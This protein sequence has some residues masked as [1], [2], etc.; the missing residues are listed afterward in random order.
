MRKL[1]LIL[2]GV[3]MAIT[4]L[5]Q[6]WPAQYEG[7]MLQGFG[8]GS[9]SYTQWNLFTQKA[10][11]IAGYFDLIWMP[12]SATTKSWQ[13]YLNG[14]PGQANGYALSN[15]EM[16]EGERELREH[17]TYKGT[18]WSSLNLTH[19]DDIFDM[20]Y[21]CWKWL[22]QE[23]RFGT[24]AELRNMIATYKAKGTG[25]IE[26]VVINHK[27]GTGDGGM[28]YPNESVQGTV[29]GRTYSV[30][31]DNTNH[32]DVC[33][34]DYKSYSNHDSWFAGGGATDSGEN[35]PYCPDLDHT[36]T[37]VQNNV[38]TYLDYLRNEIGYTGFR[39]DA[40]KG[41]AGEYMAKYIN[42]SRPTFAVGEIWD[43]QDRIERFYAENSSNTEPTCAA[44]DFQL[45]WAINDAFK[46]GNWGALNNV[47]TAAK[48]Q[49][50]RYAITFVD[51]HD[52]RREYWA[53]YD[54][55]SKSGGEGC[56]TE[57]AN[58]F[59]LMMP[60]T[61][62]VLYEDYLNYTKT[63]QDVIRIRH[64]VG[65]HN[66]SGI[67]QV[68]TWDNNKGIQFRIS[69]KHGEAWINLGNAAYRNYAH[70]G[71]TEAYIKEGDFFIEYTTGLD[72][73]QQSGR[74]TTVNGYPV[75]DKNSGNYTSQVTVNVQPN[76][77]ECTLVYTT[78]G[79]A[80]NAGS[81]QIKYNNGLGTD[82]T[83]DKTT[84][85]KVGVLVDGVVVDGSVVTRDYVINESAQGDNVKVYLKVQGATSENKPY[86]YAFTDDGTQKTGDFPGWGLFDF[87]ENVGGVDWY[88]AEIP[89]SKVNLIFSW[90]DSS[91]QTATIDDVQ[92]TVFYTFEYRMAYD[93][94]SQ[95]INAIKDP[96]VSIEIPSGE[97]TGSVTTALTPSF[98]KGIIVYTTDG[99][100]SPTANIAWNNS[101]GRYMATATGNSIVS[102]GATTVTLNYK[103]GQAQIIRAAIVNP[104]DGRL[105]H[106]VA[107]SYWIKEGSG[108]GGSITTN[109]VTE[110]I[111]TTGTNIF[112]KKS[113]YQGSGTLHVHAWENGGSSLTTHPGYEFTAAD[114]R[115]VNGVEY[116]YHHFNQ[117]NISIQLNPGSNSNQAEKSLPLAGNYFFEYTGN[118]ASAT[119]ISQSS[120]N[121]TVNTTTSQIPLFSDQSSTLYILVRSTPDENTAPYIRTWGGT[122]SND[123]PEVMTYSITYNGHKY[124]YMAFSSKPAGII[125]CNTSGY[126]YQTINIESGFGSSGVYTYWYYRDENNQSNRYGSDGGTTNPTTSSTSTTRTNNVTTMTKTVITADPI[127]I[128]VK[129]SDSSITPYVWASNDDNA[130]LTTA[131]SWPGDRM[132]TTVVD[133]VT[134]YYK[135]I[136]KNVT[137]AKLII[138]N[139]NTNGA[140]NQSQVFTV[141]PGDY[142]FSYNGYTDAALVSNITDSKL[143]SCVLPLTG[144]IKYCYFENNRHFYS[145]YIYLW[146]E[147]EET[148]AGS[149]PGEE[150]VEA[151][152]TS[153]NG[154][155]IYRWTYSGNLIPTTLNFS[156]RGTNDKP[157][158]YYK[159]RDLSF[160]NGGYYNCD[161]LQG[162]ASG[163]VWKLADIIRS[164]VPGE[165]YVIDNSLYAAYYNPNT[166]GD[167]QGSLFVRD[168]DGEAV[169][170]NVPAPGDK[171]WN[172][173]FLDV[174][175]TPGAYEQA[176]W[177]EIRSAKSGIASWQTLEGKTI[178]GQT[179]YGTFQKEN[180]NPVFYTDYT[181]I[182]INAVAT[183][184]ENHYSPAHFLQNKGEYFLVEPKPQEVILL[185]GVIY[186]KDDGKF[187]ADPKNGLNASS[188]EGIS[189]DT[190]NYWH[191]DSDFATFAS[192]ITDD[193]PAFEQVRA[194]VKYKTAPASAPALNGRT[195]KATSNGGN[196]TVDLITAKTKDNVVT[197]IETIK[198]DTDKA[199]TVQA[200]R[201]YNLMGVGSNT[202]FDGVN[203]VVTTY[204]DGTQSS[205][206][207][208]R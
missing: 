35:I 101:E 67:E 160:T 182:D 133:G 43:I 121:V 189:I 188:D 156:E 100:S 42:H 191:D 173:T 139:G 84:T 192:Q 106:E 74:V 4:S 150:L 79:L 177:I 105:V 86:V 40:A 41:F 170:Y 37:N 194:I 95:Y 87:T 158:Y 66:Q 92:G 137:S 36:G 129:C 29:T 73:T 83:F 77:P 197:E 200:V 102:D 20:G 107:R 159:T 3:L 71:F 68:V 78:N 6:G 144:D 195:I 185:N 10:D 196:F 33:Q 118:S 49:L 124:W 176:N 115:K 2:A 110:N 91:T 141:T 16:I 172:K 108:G 94:T 149:W 61:P 25:I 24:E 153:P 154:N 81:K 143:P 13:G 69:G 88:V 93:L 168:A 15:D 146:D 38:M 203:I 48:W 145:P 186:N 30:N 39:F 116:Y 165:K 65:I 51:N 55:S 206:K 155:T 19:Y 54:C 171:I 117:S 82:L 96:N 1:S 119:D 138:N 132:T 166:I 183:P 21:M 113:T 104:Q 17:G 205:T 62:C 120:G 52:T 8:W 147:K 12:Q 64:T 60:G 127:N 126:Q 178:M 80:P 32:T 76:C 198:G 63:I 174:D 109:T 50:K 163:S 161:G 187:Y 207:L 125:F 57:A 130:Y 28:D 85:L 167:S 9:Y 148:I 11:E 184:H 56:K 53:N 70:T 142:Y 114:V 128:Y 193:Y 59:L 190:S 152:G 75:I 5:A 47:G 46:N 180:G 122:P 44:F 181:P 134:W 18:S 45:K 136:N 98:S 151:V 103:N 89:A 208:L 131:T 90:G 7:V 58:A 202:P 164:G 111:P 135:Q 34:Y 157:T 26:D 175:Y 201:Y 162:V 31:W 204:T 99:V 14:E 27:D 72:W 179:F 22:Q 199:K 140:G 23:S 169:N 112:V 123:N 97:Y